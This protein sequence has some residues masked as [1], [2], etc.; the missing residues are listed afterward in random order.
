[1]NIAICGLGA[2]GSRVALE[3][4]RIAQPNY[5]LI[6]DDRVEAKNIANQAYLLRHVRSLK[7]AAIAHMISEISP[8][9]HVNMIEK[10]L[11][12]LNARKFLSGA[13]LV[14][15]AF[16]NAESRIAVSRYS[17]ARCLHVGMNVGY[18]GIRWDDENYTV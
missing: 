7:V 5:I 6:D 15:D 13:D 8:S 4:A 2:I 1:M 10:R 11:T 17:T 14:V 9:S 16:D 18:G 12:H 3:L